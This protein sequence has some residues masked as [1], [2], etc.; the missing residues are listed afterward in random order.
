V[1]NRAGGHYNALATAR[2]SANRSCLLVRRSTSANRRRVRYSV[3]ANVALEVLAA[4]SATTAILT[5]LRCLLPSF[6]RCLL[7]TFVSCYVPLDRAQ[8]TWIDRET[9]W[10]TIAR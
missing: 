2:H 9:S 10:A 3:E 6:V 5:R 4:H 7:A 1:P 8:I